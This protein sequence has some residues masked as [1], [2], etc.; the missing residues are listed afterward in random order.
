MI[1]CHF[2][3]SLQGFLNGCCPFI[4][5]D[6]TFLKGKFKGILMTAIVLDANKQIF[7]LC[8]AIVEGENKDSWT[9][10]P[11]KFEKWNWE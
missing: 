4:G 11:A 2:F 3:S 10:L 7:P 9:F 6:G 1:F 5:L 8:F